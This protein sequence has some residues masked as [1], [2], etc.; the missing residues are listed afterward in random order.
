[1]KRLFFVL[2][3]LLPVCIAQATTVDGLFKKY[4][5]IPDAQYVKMNHKELM[6]QIDSVSSEDEKEVLRTAKE[7][8]MLFFSGNEDNA[9][10][11]TTELNSLKNYYLALSFTHNNGEQSVN[12]INEGNLSKEAIRGFLE[13]FINPTISVDVYGKETS[14]DND[15]ISK[16]LFLISFWGMTGL[17]YIDG[18]IKASSADKVINFTTDT[19][20]TIKVERVMP[21]EET[22]PSDNDDE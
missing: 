3:F 17:L 7:M 2:V 6:A 19:D 22:D 20:A 16:P 11:L 15:I 21:S 12:I 5:K 18:E 10:E 14:K 4:K 8:R 1:M 13:S 9:E